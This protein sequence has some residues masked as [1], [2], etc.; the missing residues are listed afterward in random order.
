MSVTIPD[1]TQAPP[2]SGRTKLGRYAWLARLADKVRA[3]HAGTSADYICYCDLSKG[4]LNAAGV[5]QDAFDQLISGGATD[6]DLVRYFDE[7]VSD[8]QC[9]A[10]NCFV[11]VD[12]AENL[13]KQDAEEG[14]A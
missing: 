5:S 7:N 10:A 2:R 11:L 3:D 12:K 6:D 9:D 14:Y 13:D 1:F 8:A 4:F